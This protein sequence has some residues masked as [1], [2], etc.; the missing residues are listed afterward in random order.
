M[1]L[2]ATSWSQDAEGT[3][4]NPK[5]L[6]LQKPFGMAKTVSGTGRL[7]RRRSFSTLKMT[8]AEAVEM[9]VSDTNLDDVISPTCTDS[10]LFKPF[11]LVIFIQHES[12]F[13]QRE[14]F[15]FI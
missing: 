1:Q 3:R 14:S 2:N 11:T 15:L 8:A 7:H 9:S 12:S 10:P 13:R 4:G 5:T 6:A